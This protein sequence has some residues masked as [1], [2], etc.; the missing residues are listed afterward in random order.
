ML[1]ETP[2][3]CVCLCDAA[4]YTI[5]TTVFDTS[6]QLLVFC[7]DSELHVQT[8]WSTVEWGIN[9]NH[10]CTVTSQYLTFVIT[11]KSYSRYI[12]FFLNSIFSSLKL[13]PHWPTVWQEELGFESALPY[14]PQ[15]RKWSRAPS[16]LLF[17]PLRKP[18]G[19]WILFIGVG[20]VEPNGYAV[21]VFFTPLAARGST[22]NAIR[23]YMEPRH[24]M[25]LPKQAQAFSSMMPKFEF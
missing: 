11:V 19:I 22:C 21:L 3:K 7:L 18:R 13:G 5:S 2:Q 20:A 6:L 8:C 17:C 25:I 9:N 24:C 4:F 1:C 14:E 15:H 16:Q 23:L 10:S 12:L